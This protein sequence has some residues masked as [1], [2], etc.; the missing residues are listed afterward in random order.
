MLER[1]KVKQ[2]IFT[3][4]EEASIKEEYEV[5]DRAEKAASRRPQRMRNPPKWHGDSVIMIE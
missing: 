3:I 1:Q 2:V 5:E 4:P